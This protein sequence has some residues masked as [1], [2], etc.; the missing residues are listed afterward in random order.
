[1]QSADRNAIMDELSRILARPTLSEFEASMEAEI[2]EFVMSRVD[3]TTVE[4]DYKTL[5]S[6]FWKE[7]LG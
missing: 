1:M 2:L 7:K 3:N 6:L 4:N 5:I